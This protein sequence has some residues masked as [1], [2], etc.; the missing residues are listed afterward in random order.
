MCSATCSWPAVPRPCRRIPGE[1]LKTAKSEG[2]GAL[3]R[4]LR[5]PS[6]VDRDYRDFYRIFR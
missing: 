4:K 5:S 1:L 3:M 6:D 2:S